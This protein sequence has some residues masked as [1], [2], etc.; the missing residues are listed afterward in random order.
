MVKRRRSSGV[1]DE[2]LGPSQDPLQSS[3]GPSV[4]PPRRVSASTQDVRGSGSMSL[5]ASPPPADDKVCQ[6]KRARLMSDA[7]LQ[8]LPAVIRASAGRHKNLGILVSSMPTSVLQQILGYLAPLELVQLIRN[9]KIIRRLL[10]SGGGA[11]IWRSA[12]AIFDVPEP[13][14]DFNEAR[15]AGLLF[16]LKCQGCKRPVFHQEWD[17]DW[18]VLRRLCSKCRKSAKIWHDYGDYPKEM[19]E[20]VPS[21]HRE[22]TLVK[23]AVPKGRERTGDRSLYYSDDVLPVAKEW[24]AHQVAIYREQPGARGRFEA[25]KKKRKD[26]IDQRVKNTPVYKKWASQ[27]KQHDSFRN[28][29]LRSLKNMLSSWYKCKAVDIEK[30]AP[31]IRQIL[32]YFGMNSPTKDLVSVVMA[33]VL[34]MVNRLCEERLRPLTDARFDAL[35]AMYLEYLR[36]TMPVSL[37]MYCP[38]LELARSEKHPALQQILDVSEELLH[39]PPSIAD[40]KPFLDALEAYSTQCQLRQYKYWT[41]LLGVPI[42]TNLYLARHVFRCSESSG[43]P[44]ILHGWQDC[45]F[46]LCRGLWTLHSPDLPPGALEKS[47]HF[48]EYDAKSSA[49]AESLI[50]QA[51]L[52]PDVTKPEEMDAVGPQLVCAACRTR[53]VLTWRLALAHSLA[54]AGH[55]AFFRAWD[56]GISNAE[57]YLQGVRATARVWCCNL[58][59]CGHFTGK[60]SACTLGEVIHHLVVEHGRYHSEEKEDYVQLGDCANLLEKPYVVPVDR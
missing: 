48:V 36:V 43:D 49:V 16:D 27:M 5:V 39:I 22:Y 13:P 54:H 23:S 57:L 6:V 17:V 8:V 12:R 24:D 56:P 35:H 41:E 52:D 1:N 2:N 26:I 40:L 14:K 55:D 20:Y 46:H 19:F 28:D 58:W 45:I 42:S 15:W 9:T 32:R 10:L 34:P 4:N 29:N 33:K 3:I 47:F 51:G 60:E 53:T 37:S 21:T 30:A 50:K 38:P 18:H 59:H 7:D 25:W 31:K 11:D 44:Q